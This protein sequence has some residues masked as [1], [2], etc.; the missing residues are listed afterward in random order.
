MVRRLS[1]WGAAAAVACAGLAG[2]A[3]VG[4]PFADPIDTSAALSGRATSV[5]MTAVELAGDRFVAVGLRGTVLLS[6]D[7]GRHWRQAPVP[8]STDLV[9]VHFPTPQE[10][11]I[12]G[13][14]GVILHSADGGLS[15]HKQLDGRQ[16]QALLRAAHAERA[17]A[18]DAAA[19]HVLDEIERDYESGTQQPLLAI[20]FSDARH[21]LAV[22][23]FGIA[24]ETQDG[25]STWSSAMD[26]FDNPGLLHL[27]AIS[28]VGEQVFISSEKGTV[29]RVDAASRRF[30]ATSTGYQGSLF[31][32]VAER[33]AV[34]AF[35]LRGQ[36]F[37]SGDG[38]AHWQKLSTGVE[39]GLNGGALAPSQR[40]LI[41]SQGGQ[42]L[43]SDDHGQ[44]FHV[45]SG[46]VA[47]PFAGV[48]AAAKVAVVVGLN[49]VQAVDLPRAAD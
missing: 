18:G 5:P 20:R 33:D 44:T 10:G 11:W 43:A 19:K 49:G 16:L 46:L 42:L 22:G 26:R 2:V 48:A 4:P 25:G 27:F 28:G 14:D 45:L 13:H 15:W 1:M 35:G 17:A 21:G 9:A 3:A 8:V 38:A 37:R 34:T 41:A 36:A 39:A 29:F 30:V 23:S 31:G 24:V 7:A 32:H 47:A 6:D 12:S 40:L